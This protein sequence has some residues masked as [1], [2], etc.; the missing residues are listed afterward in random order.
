MEALGI[1]LPGLITQIISFLILLFVLS[2][3]LYKPV[4]KM[5]DDRAE[6]IKTSLSAAEKAKEQAEKASQYSIYSFSENARPKAVGSYESSFSKAPD[7]VSTGEINDILLAGCD[8]LKVTDQIVSASAYGLITETEFNFVSSIL[9]SK[10]FSIVLLL[11][12][13]LKSLVQSFEQFSNL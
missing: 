9:L 12:F 3:L 8:A 11:T 10:L 2:K 1:N 6:R 7:T 4:I 5:L 13:N